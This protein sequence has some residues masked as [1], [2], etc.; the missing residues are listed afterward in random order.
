MPHNY[1]DLF[2]EP[3]VVMLQDADNAIT[4]CELWGWLKNYVPEENKGF[5]F[6]EHPNLTRINNAMKYQGHS[7]SSYGW[8]MRQMEQI[9]KLGWDEFCAQVNNERR[10]KEDELKQRRA[11]ELVNV[12]FHS[13]EIAGELIQKAFAD[14]NGVVNPLTI[15]EASRGVPGF[16]GQADAMK[17]FSEGKMSYAE[18]RSLCG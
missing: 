3:E 13:S 15:A 10:K 5:M 12:V 2:Y 9:A 11:K 1:S 8:T 14:N 4:T 16:E 7:G 6:S 17:K 18:M